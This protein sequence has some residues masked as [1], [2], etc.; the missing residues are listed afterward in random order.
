MRKIG[1]LMVSL[2]KN[3]ATFPNHPILFR[4]KKQAQQVT[5]LFIFYAMLHIDGKL[6]IFSRTGNKISSHRCTSYGCI[7]KSSLPP[8]YTSYIADTSGWFERIR[9]NSWHRPPYELG[10]SIICR[11]SFCMRDKLD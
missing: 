8:L 9:L 7:L 3:L 1:R 4:G 11:R 2:I 10:R 6:S 5:T